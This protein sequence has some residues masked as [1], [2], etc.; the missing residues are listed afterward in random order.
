M[1][2]DSD[3]AFEIAFTDKHAEAKEAE[4]PMKFNKGNHDQIETLLS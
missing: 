2:L 4:K 3:D 1:L